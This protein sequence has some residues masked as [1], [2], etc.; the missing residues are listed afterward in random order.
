MPYKIF[1]VS[2][3]KGG[4]GWIYFKGNTSFVKARPTIGV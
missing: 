2:T 4:S 3:E 1:D